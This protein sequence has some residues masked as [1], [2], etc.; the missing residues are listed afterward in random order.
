M[1]LCVSVNERKIEQL[2]LDR[3][4]Y[5]VCQSLCEI[6]TTNLN[7]KLVGLGFLIKLEIE[8]YPTLWLM[9][10]IKKEVLESNESIDFFYNIR[11]KNIKI[12]LEGRYI[13]DYT[14]M[15]L[16]IT[17]IQ[18]LSI[19]RI[20]EKYFLLPN[21]EYA[22]D[23]NKLKN[24]NIYVPQQPKEVIIDYVIATIDDINKNELSYNAG[25]LPGLPG[26][27]I[28]LDKTKEVIGIFNKGHADKK[29]NYGDL[30]YPIIISLEKVSKSTN[31]I[32]K[33]NDENS[34]KI[35]KN[36]EKIL[37]N[38]LNMNE[39]DKY[40]PLNNIKISTGLSG[41]NKIISKKTEIIKKIRRINY[42]NGESYYGEFINDQKH[43]KGT[44]YYK[45]GTIKYEGDFVNDKFQ[46]NGKY[47]SE[48]GKYYKGDF[49]N[50]KRHGKGIL[51]NKNATILYEGDFVNDKF[52]GKGT[53]KEIFWMIKGMEK[54]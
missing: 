22:N 40:Q 49:Y 11:K 18:I 12:K 6:N 15:G 52:E 34:K 29:E 51:Y 26:T 24:K 42:E 48:N 32:F 10:N 17:I 23:Y 7:T 20:K 4:L 35:K 19:D 21:I 8:K 44:L 38:N 41:N 5:E 37:E 45:N 39:N 1:G 13:E 30:I 54:E 28:I 31:N 2:K 3:N 36:N 14:Y 47:I 25:A 43:G 53:I 27:P 46:G 16:D 33:I 50:G 9:T